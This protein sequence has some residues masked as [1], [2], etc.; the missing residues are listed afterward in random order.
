MLVG[1]VPMTFRDQLRL[2]IARH[3]LPYW[4]EP[5]ERIRNRRT[6]AIRLRSIRARMNAERVLG[7]YA[8]GDRILARPYMNRH[9][10]D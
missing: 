1:S 7:D 2:W 10:P 9:D 8:E 4:D 3:L 5:T 6:E